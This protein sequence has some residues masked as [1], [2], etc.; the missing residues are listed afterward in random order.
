MVNL[1]ETQDHRAMQQQTQAATSQA[2]IDAS[3][4][5]DFTTQWNSPFDEDAWDD[6]KHEAF[7]RYVT[8][9]IEDRLPWLHT[10]L[11]ATGAL[12]I[13]NPG[14]FHFALPYDGQTWHEVPEMGQ[15][16]VLLPWAED[17]ETSH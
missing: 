9:V 7:E 6:D 11:K 14:A 15:F 8:L 2:S 13:A 3:K 10:F 4:G 16:T 12:V 17:T 5:W 1:S